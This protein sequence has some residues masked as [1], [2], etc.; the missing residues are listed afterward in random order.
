MH[1]T[2]SLSTLIGDIITSLILSANLRTVLHRCFLLIT[3]S[4]LKVRSAKLLITLEQQRQMFKVKEISLRENL[5]ITKF[6]SF[7]D[8]S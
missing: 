5:W 7:P 1:A 8:F 6:C 4:I 3:I 2:L